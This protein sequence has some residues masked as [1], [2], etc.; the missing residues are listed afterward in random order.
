MTE[1]EYR[2]YVRDAG[3]MM[4]WDYHGSDDDASP[5]EPKRSDW[6]WLEGRPVAVDYAN[7]KS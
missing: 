6:G 1:V 7:L 4:V 3:L 5:I 2:K